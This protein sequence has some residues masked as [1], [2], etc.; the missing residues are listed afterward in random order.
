[1]FLVR[2]T[3]VYGDDQNLFIEETVRDFYI[4]K[5]PYDMYRISA[6]IKGSANAVIEIFSKK[7]VPIISN[8]PLFKI[9]TDDAL[10]MR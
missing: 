7:N 5:A 4:K 3:N 1:M 2:V 8:Y 9:L 6:E 10:N